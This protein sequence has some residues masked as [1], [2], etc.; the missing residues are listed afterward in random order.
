VRIAI[1]TTSYPAFR[2]DPCGH[3]VETEAFRRSAHE[4]VFVVTAKHE[5]EHDGRPG[6]EQAPVSVLRL[7]G[8]DAFGWPGLA[9]R[10]RAR[11]HL[12]LGAARWARRA[13]GALLSLSPLDRI[14]AH[15]AV[16]C[17]WPI[18]TGVGVPV[19]LVSHGADVR[20]LVSCPASLRHAFL[21]RLLRDADAWR[22][23]SA[24]L[25]E[26][27]VSSLDAV[28][29]RRLSRI[30][31]VEACPID[32]PDVRGAA[33]E[34]RA[35]H[36]GVRLAVCVARLVPKKRVDRVIEHVAAVAGAGRPI[37]LI[38]VGDGPLLA[39]LL[40]RARARRVDALFVGQTTRPE[41]LAW[42]GAADVVL[43]ASEAEGLS[44]VEREANALGV[45]FRY[46]GPN[47][48][49]CVDADLR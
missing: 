16:P 28:D 3:F 6:I 20:A 23:V 30:A 44:T 47:A 32:V 22:F 19:E 21:E 2:G 29:A 25:L 4:D 31:R 17:G 24:S 27:L 5:H 9:S 15:L 48:G 34:K 33:E 46:L 35:R 12:L 8:Y 49:V 11:P 37:R 38:V 7:D 36:A 10:V 42:I 18:S 43:N 14:V 41:A 45:P 1:V 39:K 40:E 13:R 26:H